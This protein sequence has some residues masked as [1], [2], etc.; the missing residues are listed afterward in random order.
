LSLYRL[1]VHLDAA[2]GELHPYG[3]LALQVE[4]I[5]RETGQQVAL[6]HPRISDK[7]DWNENK[8]FFSTLYN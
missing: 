2:G 7:D 5:P 6:P 3:A 4:L 8:D 1:S